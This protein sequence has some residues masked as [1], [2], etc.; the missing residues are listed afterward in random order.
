MQTAFAPDWLILAIEDRGPSHWYRF[1]VEGENTNCAPGTY[2]HHFSWSVRD[3]ASER[4]APHPT[5]GADVVAA[6][7]AAKTVEAR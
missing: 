3:V 5:A 2:G 6:I 1:H 4:Y 7:L